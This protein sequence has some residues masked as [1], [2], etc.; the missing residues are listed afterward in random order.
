[1][2]VFIDQKEVRSAGDGGV[3]I[4]FE[5]GAVPV[6][7][8]LSGHDV[9]TAQQ[10]LGLATAMGLDDPHHDIAALGLAAAGGAQHFVGLA[11]ARG[12]AQENLQAPLSW[13][14]CRREQG[15]RVRSAGLVLGHGA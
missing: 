8:G 1:M 2:G 7:D 13:P 10:G 14:R 6:G 12:H 5:E 3:D 4:K 15:V 11:H 9:Q